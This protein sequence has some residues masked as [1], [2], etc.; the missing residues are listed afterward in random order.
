[1]NSILRMVSNK[2]FQGIAYTLGGL[3][4]LL[5]MLAIV[6]KAYE[7]VD[8]TRDGIYPQK[9]M[10]VTGD[11]KISAKPDQAYLFYDILAEDAR[12][13]GARE[14]YQKKFQKFSAGLTALGIDPANVTTTSFDISEDE[15]AEKDKRYKATVTV[16]VKVEDK[17][18]IDATL[19]AVYDL[20]TKL[21]MKTSVSYGNTQC[22]GFTDQATYFTPQLHAQAIENAKQKAYELVA[23]TGLSV[24]AIVGVSSYD[25]TQYYPQPGSCSYP[26]PGVPLAPVELTMSVNLTFEVR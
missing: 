14:K 11:A 22:A 5:V 6:L 20:A 13:V 16:Q 19:N 17:K 25:S 23:S 12:E 9:T 7:V 24:G 15:G 1:M 26:V 21:K 8:R 3:L 18:A 2:F 10:N 4:I